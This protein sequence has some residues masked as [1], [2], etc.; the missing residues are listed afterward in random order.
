MKIATIARDISH[1]PNMAANDAAILECVAH[2]LCTREFEVIEANDIKQTDG[3][4]AV[5]HMSRSRE[6]LQGLKSS[7]RRGIVVINR[8]AAVENCSRLKMM[9]ILEK[10]GI[11][12]PPFSI[13]D[14]HTPLD[15]LRYPAWL[16]RAE[17]WS[18]HKGDVCFVRSAGEAREALDG[19][20]S[21]DIAIA[22]HCEHITG[23]IVKFYGVGRQF[24]HYSYPDPEKS[25]F[26]LEKI[27]GTPHRYPFC[28]EKMKETIFAA[29]EA[30]GIEIY[31][32]DCII[33]EDGCISIIDINDFP[34]FSAIRDEA[35]KK[36]AEH[37]TN[38]INEKR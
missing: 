12:Q 27:N 32:G 8:P 19:M 3:C 26:G 10:A 4:M 1:S 17:G 23:D 28:L 20:H 2:E 24:F 16:K 38:K 25:K 37:I 5:C 36:I 31:G 7:E 21:R 18:V 9:Q 35:A 15:I 29:A 22:I 11:P 13:I 6:I 34:S 33:R 14:E 30:I